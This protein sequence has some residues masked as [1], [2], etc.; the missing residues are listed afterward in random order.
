M[1]SRNKHLPYKTAYDVVALGHTDE[2]GRTW[3]H[4]REKLGEGWRWGV[5]PTSLSDKIDVLS[6]IV[7]LL[8]P[9]IILASFITV[10]LVKRRQDFFQ[11]GAHCM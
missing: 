5:V 7:L 1:L 6:L 8:I 11:G 4:S 3:R 2:S 10:K 9:Y